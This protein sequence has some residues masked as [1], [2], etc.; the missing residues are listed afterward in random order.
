MD[1][2]KLFSALF[3]L[4]NKDSVDCKAMRV[5]YIDVGDVPQHR[6]M[7]HIQKVKETITT[8]NG[9]Q[10][11]Y[12]PR[13]HGDSEM[14][15]IPLDLDFYREFSKSDLFITKDLNVQNREIF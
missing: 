3:G 6:A 15:F 12:L 10:D 4:Q 2:K 1:G 9:V 7:E 13:R 5:F 11:I 8:I 14:Q